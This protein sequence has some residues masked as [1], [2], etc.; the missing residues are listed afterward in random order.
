[1]ANERLSV[2]GRSPLFRHCFRLVPC[3]DA[4]VPTIVDED[5]RENDCTEDEDAEG[6]EQVE[7][8]CVLKRY[9]VGSNRWFAAAAVVERRS[10]EAC[11]PDANV[12]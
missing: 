8:E 12:R 4:S 9:G 1:M 7:R 10:F 5:R 6:W 3:D 11:K 2:D